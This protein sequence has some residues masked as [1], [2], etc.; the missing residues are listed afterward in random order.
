MADRYL[1]ASGNSSNAAIFDGGTFPAAV[2]TLR[3]NGFTLTVDT[4]FTVA[5]ITNNIAGGA[6]TARG[7]VVLNGG[8]VLNADVIV[9]SSINDYQFITTNYGSATSTING[10]GLHLVEGVRSTVIEVTG[11][12]DGVLILNGDWRHEGTSGGNN[13]LRAINLIGNGQGFRVVCNGEVSGSYSTASLQANMHGMYCDSGYIIDFNGLVTGRN[14]NSTSNSAAKGCRLT[15]SNNVVN[16]NGLALGGLVTNTGANS[17]QSQAIDAGNS[18]N[19]VNLFGNAVA[20][21]TNRAIVNGTVVF[22]SGANIID[23]P[24]NVAVSGRGERLVPF[25]SVIR[26]MVDVNGID[27]VN[28]YT[29]SLL[30]GYPVEANVFDSVVYGPAGEFIGTLSPVNVDVQLLADALLANMNTSNLPIAE[31]LRDGMGASAAA[32]AAVGS[33]N[34]IP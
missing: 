9:R 8:V 23:H 13:E 3:T 20:T 12:P 31:G 7:E 14:A 29:A 2:D 1:I 15:G 25:A 33:I 5:E 26:E 6:T 11:Q 34:V 22:Q 27:T 21:L 24:E 18:T 32:I 17:V 30:T 4:D 19:V 10:N 16:V 28:M